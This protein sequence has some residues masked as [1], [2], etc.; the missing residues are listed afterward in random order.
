[1]HYQDK[2]NVIDI[3][4]ITNIAETLNVVIYIKSQN[5]FISRKSREVP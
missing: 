5:A 3:S 1:M 4:D 2:N